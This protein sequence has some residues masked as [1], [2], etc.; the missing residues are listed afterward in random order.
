MSGA[1]TWVVKPERSDPPAYLRLHG[2]FSGAEEATAC[3]ESADLTN[4]HIALRVLPP[5]TA[6]DPA[7]G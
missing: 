1:E 2:P 4:S 7:E 6:S 3:A 5:T